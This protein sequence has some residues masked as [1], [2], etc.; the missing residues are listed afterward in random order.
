M[1]PFMLCFAD[2]TS[3]F[4]GVAAVLLAALL[5]LRF[6]TGL[7][8]AVLKA[9][10][11]TGMV[12]VIISATPLPV[13]AY[14]V[15]VAAGTAP[16]LLCPRRGT[17]ERAA[18]N[19]FA[20]GPECPLT[21][22]PSPARGEGRNCSPA[23]G[24]G[25][26][27]WPAGKAGLV[28]VGVLLV[29]SV[30]LCAAEIPYHVVPRVSIGPGETIYVLGDSLSAGIGTGERC[31]PAVLGDMT[32]L[33]VVN[34]ARPGAKLSTAMEQVK[35][36]TQANA[37]VI[38]EIGG[39]DLLDGGD[40]AVF[41][42]QLDAL[43]GSLRGHRPIL[44]FE[45]PLFPF[46][47]AFGRAQREVAAKYGVIL[48]PKRC[49]TAVLGL[50]G[51]TLDGLHLSQTGHKAMARIVA[52]VLGVAAGPAAGLPRERAGSVAPL[53]GSRRLAASLRE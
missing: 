2:G 12:A 17:T 35:G 46:R 36:A 4:A 33:P 3:F 32:Q 22:D 49:L 41:R 5:L 9:V 47:N 11:L 24:E 37:A 25:R 20:F 31:W 10:A 52:G 19:C 16:L 18:K 51:G 8:A 34:L 14:A 6:P 13:W 39:N 27:C 21:P 29:A 28:S 43:V 53:R 40:A 50:R 45:L 15:W 30:G 42:Q 26:N 44:M 38:L 1:N 7:V 48:I 23:N